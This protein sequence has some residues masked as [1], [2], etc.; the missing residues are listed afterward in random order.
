MNYEMLVNKNNQLDKTYI[1]KDLVN[2]IAGTS[3]LIT[4]G[5]ITKGAFNKG[6]LAASKASQVAETTRLPK[7]KIKTKIG[8]K[9]VNLTETE[10]GAVLK[11]NYKSEAELDKTIASFLNKKYNLEE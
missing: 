8:I 1:P 3:A 10:L 2:A 4:G 7:G 11:N 5:A 6:K 9:D